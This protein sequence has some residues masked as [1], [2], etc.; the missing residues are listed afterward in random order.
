MKQVPI[1]L[2]L[3]GSLCTLYSQHG[4][5]YLKLP[6]KYETPSL[7][8][9]QSDDR[10]LVNK[11]WRVYTDRDNVPVY[12]TSRCLRIIDTANFMESYVAWEETDRALR[13]AGQIGPGEFLDEDWFGP[14]SYEKGWIKK[15]HLILTEWALADGG[16]FYRAFLDRTVGATS[17]SDGRHGWPKEVPENGVLIYYVIKLEGQ[18]FLLSVTDQM[19]EGLQKDALF[20]ISSDQAEVLVSGRGL[21][22][23]WE[24]LNEDEPAYLYYDRNFALNNRQEYAIDTIIDNNP[25]L[26]FLQLKQEENYFY[27]AKSILDLDGRTVYINNRSRRFE[28]ALLVD[29]SQF[30]IFKRVVEIFKESSMKEEL[31]EQLYSLFYEQGLEDE[32]IRDH[33]LRELLEAITNTKLSSIV[34][35]EVKGFDELTEADFRAYKYPYMSIWEKLDSERQLSKY[36]LRSESNYYWLPESW[37]RPDY[38][39][40]IA[41]EGV[42]V[43]EVN[44]RMIYTDYDFIYIDNSYGEEGKSF[45]KLDAEINKCDITLY[46]IERR[47]ATDATVGHSFFYS[48]ALSPISGTDRATLTNIVLAMRADKASVPFRSYDKRLIEEG[49]LLRGIERINEEMRFHFFVS[50]KTISEEV[51]H[52]PLLFYELPHR[53]KALSVAD[54]ASVTVNLYVFRREIEMEYARMLTEFVAR[55]NEDSGEINYMIVEY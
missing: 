37:I 33:T 5:S 40:E 49:L 21:V 17:Y 31:Q 12:E 30:V 1:L 10:T 6:K 53:V 4:E 13:L 8:Y 20:W 25:Y 14:A 15:E 46:G 22:P 36:R 54:D 35:D 29:Y 50:Q 16:Q 34:V 42:A 7:A 43:E 9:S 51:N 27:S 55:A 44:T 2:L 24:F 38:L 41:F 19:H 23:K 28:D 26:G 52:R 45:D 47:M 48:D 3:L 32:E 18:D 39:A 11:P